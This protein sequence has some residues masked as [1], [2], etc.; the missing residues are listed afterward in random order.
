VKERD[1]YLHS[2]PWEKH[3]PKTFAGPGLGNPDVA[4]AVFVRLPLAIPVELDFDAA[5]LVGVDLLVVWADDHGGL[6]AEDAGLL[7]FAIRTVD[8][9]IRKAAKGVL[10]SRGA[11]LERE[12]MGHLGDEVFPIERSVFFELEFEAG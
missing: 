12:G 3:E 1:R 8:S 4:A 10:V 9:L 5:M 6:E 2:D 11:P 7:R